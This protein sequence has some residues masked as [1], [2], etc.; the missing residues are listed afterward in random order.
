MMIV[1]AIIA[2]ACQQA[3]KICQYGERMRRNRNLFALVP[4]GVI[5][6]AV[7]PVQPHQ[8]THK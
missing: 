2:L 7:Q 8:H 3:L 5:N 1:I 6:I 4:L